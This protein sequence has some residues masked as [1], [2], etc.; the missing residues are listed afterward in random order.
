MKKALLSFALVVA[1]LANVLAQ[2][3]DCFY[4]N[5]TSYYLD[6]FD[7]MY[8]FAVVDSVVSVGVVKYKVFR[9]TDYDASCQGT[10]AFGININKP[11]WAGPEIHKLANGDYL[12]FNQDGDTITIKTTAQYRVPWVCHISSTNDT[13]FAQVYYEDT[14]TVYG[15]FDSVKTILFSANTP[16]SNFANVNLL[17][18]KL[19]KQHGLLTI[20]KLYTFPN[21]NQ[22]HGLA[23]TNL[24]PLTWGE[25]YN[26]SI[27]D[28]YQ[29]L[30]TRE[31]YLGVDTIIT[32][33]ELLD[34]NTFNNGNALNYT[35]RREIIRLYS[36]GFTSFTIDTIVETYDNLAD[37]IGGGL[38]GAT[39]FTGVSGEPITVPNMGLKTGQPFPDL[40]ARRTTRLSPFYDFQMLND[41]CWNSRTVVDGDE[42]PYYF[43]CLGPLFLQASGFFYLTNDRVVYYNLCGQ[44]G[45][46]KLLLG[47]PE[48]PETQVKI[49]PNPANNLLQ[50]DNASNTG[51]RISIANL[52]G[53]VVHTLSAVAAQG[54][55]VDVSNWAL[56]VYIIRLDDGANAY[57]K[58]V[59]IAR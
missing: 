48:L 29:V 50:I 2:N 53:Q 17:E 44:Q 57:F 19:T 13:L 16:F 31:Y 6:D 56:G 55:T 3:W 25:V 43:E 32:Y 35:F 38:P 36:S 11:T 23:K 46:T 10:A 14:M 20:P 22:Y 33:K 37:Y 5:D 39:H 24:K 27:G 42:P 47:I 34:K 28:Y 40:V 49:Y 52:Q 4:P 59:V 51:Y 58:K 41:T 7:E 9:T 15:V 8:G 54:T 12:F 1:T 21:E 45:G 18:L 30:Q 26:Y